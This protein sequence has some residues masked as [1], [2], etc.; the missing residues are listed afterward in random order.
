[1]FK[2]R[3]RDLMTKHETRRRFEDIILMILEWYHP[4][5][6]FFL[7]IDDFIDNCVQEVLKFLKYEI[8]AHPI[9]SIS[10]EQ[11]FIWKRNNI[12]ENY[13]EEDDAKSIKCILDKIIL[14]YNS[15]ELYYPWIKLNQID[16]SDL[17]C[18]EVYYFFYIIISYYH[19]I[20]SYYHK[21]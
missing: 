14:N 20:V 11:F 6:Y 5:K 10:P 21:Y 18:Y 17:Y 2:S 7:D 19:T 8:P 4:D 16:M 12:D 15:N 9:L 3:L 13:W 1:M